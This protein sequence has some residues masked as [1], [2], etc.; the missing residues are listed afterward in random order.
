[1]YALTRLASLATYNKSRLLGERAC[2]EAR[3]EAK[4][5]ETLR[6]KGGELHRVTPAIPLS[7]PGEDHLVEHLV[8]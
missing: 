8:E 5:S 1:M 4:A 2:E 7:K 6:P 3:H